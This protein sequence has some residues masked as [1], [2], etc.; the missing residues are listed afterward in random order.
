MKSRPTDPLLHLLQSISVNPKILILFF[1]LQRLKFPSK[2]NQFSL[3]AVIS[4][5]KLCTPSV[6]VWII[7][8]RRVTRSAV[9]HDA[10][11][12]DLELGS[13]IPNLH[14]SF[15]RRGAKRA[16]EHTE[17]AQKWV[18]CAKGSAV[19]ISMRW[20]APRNSHWAHQAWMDAAR[21]NVNT[22]T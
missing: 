9:Q 2:I 16:L 3:A 14:F 8:S 6:C 12:L 20:E 7:N 15:W 5:F 4:I 13:S 11:H 18:S 10:D 22:V 17:S 1:T 19:P 21:D